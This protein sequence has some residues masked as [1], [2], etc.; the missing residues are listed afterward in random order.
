M[1]RPDLFNGFDYA[2]ENA[3]LICEGFNAFMSAWLDL[4]RFVSGG[5]QMRSA[6]VYRDDCSHRHNYTVGQAPNPIRADTMNS[7]FSKSGI[8]QGELYKWANGATVTTEIT[9][10][11]PR[12]D[13]PTC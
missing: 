13:N 4:F 1:I 9:K 10:L 11:E 2:V 5:A 6:N 8:F 3:G 12:V 7:A